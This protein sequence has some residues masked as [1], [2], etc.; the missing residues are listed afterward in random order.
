MTR[1]LLTVI[2]EG[3][4]DLRAQ[5]A[6]LTKGALLV[7]EPNPPPEPFAEIVLRVEGVRGESAELD[8]RVLHIFAGRGMAVSFDD[9]AAAAQKLTPMFDA[10]DATETAK[11]RT[12]RI[13]WGRPEA[14]PAPAPTTTTPPEV[15]QA[16]EAGD[17]ATD[18][19]LQA[20]IAAMTP[21]QKIQL[22]LKGDR[23]ARLFL[24]KDLNKTLHTFLLQNPRIT[25]DEVRFMA[26]YK[27][28]SAE[29]LETIAANPDYMR[30][31]GIVTA[32]V[33]NPRTPGPTAA[34]LVEKLPEAEVRRLAKSSDVPRA[35]QIAA[36]KRLN[37]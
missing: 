10:A 5:R 33:R 25:L 28:T 31:Q 19:T 23:T 12:T 34:R 32:L 9:V 30:Q 17:E 7:P 14:R 26:G 6:H 37:D 27:Q 36:R 24:L 1:P 15:A 4:T 29:A 16:A 20:Q 35:V 8:A 11:D 22:A 13:V 2:F 18:A 3:A 21:P